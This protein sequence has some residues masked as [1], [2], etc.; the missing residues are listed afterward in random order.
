MLHNQKLS[1]QFNQFTQTS[2]HASIVNEIVII[3]DYDD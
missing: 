3:N 2:L 1:I